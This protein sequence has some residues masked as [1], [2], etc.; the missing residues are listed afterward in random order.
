MRS[1]SSLFVIAL[2]ALSTLARHPVNQDIVDEIKAKATTWWPVEPEDNIFK[3]HTEEQI[4]GMMGTKID[5]ERD[6]RVAD[7]MGI[8]GY[9]DESTVDLPANFDSREEWTDCPFDIKDQGHCGSCWAFGAVESLEDRICIRTGGKMKQDLSEQQMVSCN[10]VGFGCSGGW[11]L[12]AMGFLSTIGVV[13]EECQPYTSGDSGEA[14]G[15]SFSCE[16]SEV[17]SERWMCQYPWMSFTSSGIKADIKKY[18]PVETGFDVYE[19]FIQY[20]GGIY[21]YTTGGY[22]GGH[23]VKI[24]GWGEEEGTKYWLAANSW[25]ESWGEKG[26]FRIAEGQCGFAATAYSCVPWAK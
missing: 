15:C 17:S 7:E 14:W 12:S 25:S 10:F 21:K 6:R 18:G 3:F 16:D 23:A 8:T 24:V 19:D 2:L 11:P 22:L 5:E 20:S 13:T 4:I 1:Y 9:D 26:F